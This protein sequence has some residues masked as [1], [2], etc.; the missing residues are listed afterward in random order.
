[1][2]SKINP[3]Y[4]WIIRKEGTVRRT[5][6]IFVK[7]AL[8]PLWFQLCC[9]PPFVPLYLC[10]PHLNNHLPVGQHL[11]SVLWRTTWKKKQKGPRFVVDLPVFKWFDTFF[12]RFFIFLRLLEVQ[13]VISAVHSI[14][15]S[16]EKENSSG[17]GTMVT[18]LWTPEDPRSGRQDGVYAQANW[19]DFV[20]KETKNCC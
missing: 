8:F 11:V 1:M 18:K 2:A 13:G 3:K 20:F 6:I 17:S 16:S 4:E 9:V 12:W 10:P 19:N 5:T 15:W 7:A 14:S